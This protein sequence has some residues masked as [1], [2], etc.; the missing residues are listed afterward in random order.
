MGEPCVSSCQPK[1]KEETQSRSWLNYGKRHKMYS[2]G[3]ARGGWWTGDQVKIRNDNMLQSSASPPTPPLSNLK[4][5]SPNFLLPSAALTVTQ[6]SKL[7]D[8]L[9]LNSLFAVHYL[10]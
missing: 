2:K 1:I 10:S 9:I 7:N 8:M 5:K 3:C 4:H 6:I